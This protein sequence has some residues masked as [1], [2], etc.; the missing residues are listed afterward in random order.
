MAVAVALATVYLSWRRLYYGVDFTDESFYLALPLRFALGDI[1]LRDEQNLAQFA[2]VLVL[3]LVRVFLWLAGGIEGLVLFMRHLHLA[4]TALIGLSVFL[5]VRETLQWRAALV[6]ACICLVFVPFNI[7]GLSYNT[8]GSGFLTIGCFLGLYASNDPARRAWPWFFCGLSHCLA[9]LVYPTLLPAAGI[10]AALVLIRSEMRGPRKVWAWYGAGA[11][12]ASLV[13]AWM[14]WRAG[15]QSLPPIAGYLASFGAPRAGADKL[16]TMAASFV[17]ET[18]H[19][20]LLAATAALL[21]LWHFL[22]PPWLRPV[23]PLLALLPTA[24]IPDANGTAA[25]YVVVAIA[26]MGAFVRP[27]IAADP[28]ASSVMRCVWLPSIAGGLI[29]AWSSSNGT[30][31]ASIGMFPAA[32]ATLVLVQMALRSIALRALGLATPALVIVVLLKGGYADIY[33]EPVQ[34]PQ[35]TQ[36]VAAGPFKGIQTTPEKISVIERFERDAAPLIKPGDRILVFNDFPG[37]Y[38][39]AGVRPGVNSVWLPPAATSSETDRSPT[40]SYWSTT[41]H[42]PDVVLLLTKSALAVDPLV[43][44]LKDSQ[45]TPAA[46]LGFATLLLRRAAP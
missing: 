9:I 15:P 6:T 37:G 40:F 1:P 24:Y 5:A 21:V 32:L 13:P 29:T 43:R 41:G 22:R 3:P 17:R 34:L 36:R 7:H 25:L 44:H 16:A 20:E 10:F 23:L 45:F 12:I 28:F 42:R 2:A 33:G 27:I 11:A 19:V 4:F 38:L 39:L 14:L 18:P 35:L 8:M 31:N 30:P 46:D 26:L